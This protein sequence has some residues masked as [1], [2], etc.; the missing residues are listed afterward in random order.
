MPSNFPTSSFEID[1]I[2]LESL[3][4]LIVLRNL[5][6]SCGGCNRYKSNKTTYIASFSYEEVRLFHPQNDDWRTPFQ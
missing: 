2:M 1:H 5:A 4:G 6:Y 3:N